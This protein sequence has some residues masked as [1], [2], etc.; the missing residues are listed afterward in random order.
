MQNNISK[1]L[2][3][4][5]TQLE[6]LNQKVLALIHSS[7]NERVKQIK[8]CVQP[9]DLLNKLLKCNGE[10]CDSTVIT[11][12]EASVLVDLFIKKNL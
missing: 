6:S 1:E 7:T 2:T 9:D 11:W 8:E 5:S 4:V 12:R 10:K 3:E